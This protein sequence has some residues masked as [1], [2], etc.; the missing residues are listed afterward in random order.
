MRKEYHET[1][2]VDD[3]LKYGMW[4]DAHWERKSTITNGNFR[5]KSSYMQYTYRAG[6][7][8]VRLLVKYF[9]GLGWKPKEIKQKISELW[10][11][12]NPYVDFKYLNKTIASIRSK[13]DYDLVD[14]ESVKVSQEA[15]D[16]FAQMMVTD[17][18]DWVNPIE[19]AKVNIS[20]RS[21]GELGFGSCKLMFTYYIWVLI[22]KQFKKGNPCWINM[23]NTK[24][25]LVQEAHLQNWRKVFDLRCRLIDWGLVFDPMWDTPHGDPYYMSFVEIIPTGEENIEVDFENPRKWFEEYFKQSDYIEKKPLTNRCPMCGRFFERK[26]HRPDECCPECKKIKER[27]KKRKQ[28]AKNDK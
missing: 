20:D 19:K 18:M 13:K 4:I 15:M 11:N 3:I 9:S 28:R 6:A 12:Y 26:S 24:R 27:N 23:E 10:I 1:Q 14:I 22:Q 5:D 8:K 25:R 16:W 7:S 21:E 17:A 2:V